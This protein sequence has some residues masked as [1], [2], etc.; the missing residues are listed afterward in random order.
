MSSPALVIA[1]KP[2]VIRTQQKD[3]FE[4]TDG[5]ATW[6]L[7]KPFTCKFV[8]FSER[9]LG[10]GWDGN[11]LVL[12]TGTGTVMDFIAK[13]T[14]AL[15]EEFK[16]H[17]AEIRAGFKFG[18]EKAVSTFLDFSNYYSEET[19]EL[20]LFTDKDRT[21]CYQVTADSKGVV[22]LEHLI[23]GKVVKHSTLVN[24]SFNSY[25]MCEV[26]IRTVFFTLLSDSKEAADLEVNV[27]IGVKKLKT[28]RRAASESEKQSDLEALKAFQSCCKKRKLK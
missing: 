12:E 21:K 6:R 15:E 10:G 7:T 25:F 5:K 14:E 28:W 26:V 1:L 4:V 17:I 8:G 18:E 23:A 20:R 27:R 9:G 2:Q 13:A 19:G 24:E 16:L 3:K 11:L 22:E